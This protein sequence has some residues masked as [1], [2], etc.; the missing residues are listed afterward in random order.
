MGLLKLREPVDDRPPQDTGYQQTQSLPC[1]RG[2]SRTVHQ[3]QNDHI[4][5]G[6]LEHMENRIEKA[7]DYGFTDILLFLSGKPP[8][9]FQYLDHAASPSFAPM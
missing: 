3:C 6:D 4:D 8:D 1:G 9:F 7:A 5:G 2:G